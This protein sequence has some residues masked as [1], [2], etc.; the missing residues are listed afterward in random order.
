[1][2]TTENYLGGSQK[3]TFVD[4]RENCPVVV[5]SRRMVLQQSIAM[6]DM[7]G[8][9]KLSTDL[10]WRISWYHTT[11]SA[12]ISGPKK[13]SRCAVCCKEIPIIV[14]IVKRVIIN[15][16]HMVNINNIIDT[17]H[18]IHIFRNMLER[19]DNI[20]IIIIYYYVLNA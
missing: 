12:S 11:S 18:S 7:A 3:S 4:A 2:P 15:M 8:K 16:I 13:M 6:S 5:S 1:M 20:H 10:G 9:Q 19:I 14:K 17:V